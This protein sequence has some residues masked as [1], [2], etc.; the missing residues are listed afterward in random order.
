MIQELLSVYIKLTLTIP[1][2]QCAL[3]ILHFKYIIPA[4]LLLTNFDSI[5]Y[6]TLQEDIDSAVQ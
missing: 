2:P 1:F 4:K 6:V 5:L 3:E